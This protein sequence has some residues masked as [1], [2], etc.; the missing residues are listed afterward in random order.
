M[1]R[2]ALWTA[3]IVAVV[4]IAA[5][6]AGWWLVVADTARPEQHV[7]LIVPQG[8]SIAGIGRQ[9]EA[10]GVI[11]SASAFTLFVRARGEG[12]SI[13]AAEYD[14]AP[15]SSLAS[16]V[17]VLDAGGRPPTV[18]ITI[19]EGYTAAEIGS[20]LQQRGIGTRAEFM[21]VVA[22]TNV[23]FGSV[24][25]RGLEGYLFPDTY[26]I[27]IGA[28]PRDAAAI[29]TA[30]F[31][32]E[33]PRD[34]VAMARKLRRTV[35]QIVTAASLIEREAKVDVERPVMASVYY[36]RLRRGMPLQ[37]DATIEYALP[38]HKTALSFADLKIDSPYNTYLYAGLPP[39]PI[40]NPGRASLDAAFHPAATGYLYYVYK[41][42]G[43][44]Q[45]SNTLEEQQAAE[46][47]FLP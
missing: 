28:T 33:L 20:V 10:A 22:S 46:R 16:V 42:K 8:A 11:R 40:A 23:R 2:I 29:L 32:H 45:F 6:C 9:L 38:S 21:A 24:S 12:R 35:P 7:N 15:H 34:Y 14:F 17:A 26:E 13:Q 3:W 19:P 37:V 31:M 27:R 39:T 47:R 44:H 1:R 4:A 25:S 30:R 18:W 41:G 43:R 36:N 5:G